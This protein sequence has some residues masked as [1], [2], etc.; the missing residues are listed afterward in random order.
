MIKKKIKILKSELKEV[1]KDAILSS[2]K[3]G[4]EICGLLVDNGYFIE[5]IKVKNAGRRGGGFRFGPNEIKF[6]QKAAR[7]MNHKI[8]GTF[9]SHP[10][11]IAAPSD[12][13]LT[14]A[15]DHSFLLIIDVMGKEVK[16]WYIANQK[17]K[18]VEFELIK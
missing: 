12:S 3:N 18:E 4:F 14:Y 8:I 16:L 5:L 6:I 1:V 15:V 13:D 9:H 7:K 11:Y 2:K 17:K 10:T